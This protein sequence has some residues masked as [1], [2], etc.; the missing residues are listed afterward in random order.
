MDTR[1]KTEEKQSRKVIKLSDLHTQTKKE[2]KPGGF[3]PSR[4]SS[5][6]GTSTENKNERKRSKLK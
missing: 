4:S 3:I 6:T 2:T 1:L 5:S